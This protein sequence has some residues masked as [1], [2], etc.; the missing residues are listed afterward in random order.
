MRAIAMLASML[1]DK[2]IVELLEELTR[3]YNKATSDKEREEIFKRIAVASQIVLISMSLD[4]KS[5]EGM[6]KWLKNYESNE[7]KLNLFN[8]KNHN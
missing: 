3:E 6:E 7:S 5:Y 8:V 2:K 1:S 4:E